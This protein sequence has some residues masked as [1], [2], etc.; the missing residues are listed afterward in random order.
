MGISRGKSTNREIE[1]ATSE[2]LLAGT[3][4]DLDR[5]WIFRLR[6]GRLD[7]TVTTEKTWE[8]SNVNRDT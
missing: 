8:S 2:D 4:A 6:T 3:G 5:E 7:P 1:T